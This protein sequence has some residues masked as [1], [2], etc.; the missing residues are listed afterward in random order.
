MYVIHYY[1]QKRENRKNHFNHYLGSGIR[2]PSI[3]AGVMVSGT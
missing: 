1:H 3:G 2:A